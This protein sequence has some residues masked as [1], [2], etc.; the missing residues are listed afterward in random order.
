MSKKEISDFVMQPIHKRL[1]RANII[2]RVEKL[3]D[4]ETGALPSA[5]VDG[6]GEMAKSTGSLVVDELL[7]IN[8]D[9]GVADIIL[10][11]Y[12]IL[13][14][15]QEGELIFQDTAGGSTIALYSDADN[16]LVLANQF[17][18]KGISFL[19]D[20]DAH[21]VIEHNFSAALTEFNVG[22]ND[23][24]VRFKGS[25]DG[26]LTFWDAGLNRVGIGTATPDYKLDVAGDINSDGGTFRID[27]TDIASLFPLAVDTTPVEGW[28]PSTIG[29]WSY[30]TADAPT[31][32]ISIADNVTTLIG[33][34]DRIKLTQTTEK[35][36]IVTAVGSYGGGVTLVT[37]YGGTDYTLANAA[38]TSPHYS[39]VK[40]PFG[41]PMNDDKWT[42]SAADTGAAQKTTPTQDVWYGGAGTS[43]TGISVSVPIGAW[44]GYYKTVLRA[45]DTTVTG[46]N[47]YSTLSNANNTESDSNNTAFVALTTPS[48]SYNVWS[49][50]SPPVKIT[51]TTKTTYYVNIKTNTTTADSIGMLGSVVPTIIKLV[52]NYL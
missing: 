3:E 4:G 27:G 47:C 33:V 10:N 35:Y 37:V 49:V 26:D 18:G 20:D 16:F 1:N 38:I 28:I 36:F 22:L 2:S 52:C 6:L 5:R 40:S 15:N 19:I 9:T 31:F 43:A 44:R 39:H 25:T 11:P 13:F 32:V 21:N 42:V 34:G 12:G 46:F 50:V 29:T 7:V 8:H 14:R 17:G 30:S 23:V 41:F 24:D 45:V 48:G 51:V